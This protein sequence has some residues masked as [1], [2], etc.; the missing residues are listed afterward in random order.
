MLHLPKEEHDGLE[1]CAE[2]VVSVDGGG[3]IKGNVA[4]DLWQETTFTVH[5]DSHNNYLTL[6]L[7]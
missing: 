3:C 7:S 5:C 4:K 6:T 1:E 2:V